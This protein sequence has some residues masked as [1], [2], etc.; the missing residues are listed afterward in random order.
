MSIQPTPSNAIFDTLIF[1]DGIF[2]ASFGISIVNL[3]H[4]LH[5]FY[6]FYCTLWVK[7]NTRWVQIMYWFSLFYV[8]CRQNVTILPQKLFTHFGMPYR[9]KNQ[10]HRT[11][12]GNEVG[13]QESDV[14]YVQ[15]KNFLLNILQLQSIL[16]CILGIVF[17][18]PF[19][20]AFHDLIPFA[21]FKKR[22]KHPWRSVI[23]GN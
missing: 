1:K 12:K 21:Q 4:I 13:K 6:H 2:M 23:F 9:P 20:D 3:D 5:L 14:P 11:N 16:Y 7:T 10:S 22:E 15:C 17:Q 8:H 19:Y 18:H